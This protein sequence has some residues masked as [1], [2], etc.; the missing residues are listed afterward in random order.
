MLNELPVQISEEA[1]QEIKNIISRKNIPSDYGLR[2]GVKGSGCAGVSYSLGFDTKKDQDRE[3]SIENIPV[4]IEKKDVM[5]LFGITL[6]Y[7]SGSDAQGFM[8]V[9]EED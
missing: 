5:F 6:K 9:K 4:Y 8:F 2:M 3:Y 7:Y 1:L